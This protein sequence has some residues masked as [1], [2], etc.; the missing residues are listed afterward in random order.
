MTRLQFDELLKGSLGELYFKHYCRQHNY[1]YAR[2][3]HIARELTAEKRTV[4]FTLGFDRV[5]IRIPREMV[6]EVFRA[7]QPTNEASFSYVVDF[8]TCTNWKENRGESP[9]DFAWVEVK[10]GQSELSF[11]QV[12]FREECKLR[13]CV[14][15]IP[16]VW[17]P[18]RAVQVN[19]EE[20]LPMKS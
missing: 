3:E 16:K 11:N 2:T 19:W 9:E 20:D 12:K 18:P 7:S 6:A 13:F 4:T 10:T 15:R 17:L 5:A 14:F 1:L 8:L